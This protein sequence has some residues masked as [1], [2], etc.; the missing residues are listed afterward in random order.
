MKKYLISLLIL[1]IGIGLAACTFNW[2]DNSGD[3]GGDSV[4]VAPTPVQSP[5]PSA[6]PGPVSGDV[7]S[8]TYAR[9]SPYG[10]S[11]ACPASNG[12]RPYPL[13]ATCEANVTATPKLA[14]G[15]DAPT[16]L[17]GQNIVW[18]A[19]GPILYEVWP[20]NPFNV[21]VRLAAGTAAGATASLTATITLPDGRV[22]RDSSGQPLTLQF[23]AQ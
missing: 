7:S 9:L 10:S 3:T 6:K 12:T 17:H 16:E 21:D 22:L 20:T 13:T 8:I 11:P 19:S 23:V 14:N 5:S 15:T 2:N 18:S 4:I 1:V